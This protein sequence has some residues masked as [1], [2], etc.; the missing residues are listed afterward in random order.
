MQ[1]IPKFVEMEKKN[2]KFKLGI[3]LLIIS[4][5]I[6]FALFVMPFISMGTKIKITIST[7]LIIAGEVLFWT[8]TLL[9]GKEVWN[10][11]KSYI[12]S[13]DWLNKKKE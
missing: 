5:I 2:W 9:I 7:V 11:Y 3:I 1:N 6:F 13:G 4:V 10:K 8:G 12:K